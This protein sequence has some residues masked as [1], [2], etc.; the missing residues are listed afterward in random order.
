MTHARDPKR[1]GGTPTTYLVEHYRPGRPVG[2]LIAWAERIRE[3]A[4]AM[5]RDG[6]SV[7][8]VRCTIVPA[9]ESLLCLLEAATEDL[10]RELYTRARIPFERLSTAISDGGQADGDATAENRRHDGSREAK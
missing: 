4:L 5:E 7:R 8:Y 9:D 2:G 6:K 1:P 10:V 3:T